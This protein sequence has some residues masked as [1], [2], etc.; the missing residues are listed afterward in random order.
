MKIA[1]ELEGEVLGVGIDLCELDRIESLLERLGQRF[2]AR[3]YNPA[4]IALIQTGVSPARTCAGLFAAKEAVVKCLGT[5]FSAGVG[6]KQVE[7]LPEVLSQRPF[8]WKVLLHGEAA[9]R[10]AACGETSWSLDIQYTRECAAAVAI[11]SRSEGA[12]L[13]R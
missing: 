6:W 1:L 12:G 9:R 8:C 3:A 11:W 4:E 2:L 10:S 5:G 13:E 7:V